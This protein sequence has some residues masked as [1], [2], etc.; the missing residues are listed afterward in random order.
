VL[1]KLPRV[2][3]KRHSRLHLLFLFENV[4]NGDYRPARAGD[5]LGSKPAHY[6]TRGGIEES[7]YALIAVKRFMSTLRDPI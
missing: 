6:R 3:Q 1:R 7:I 5:T 4:L 2:H